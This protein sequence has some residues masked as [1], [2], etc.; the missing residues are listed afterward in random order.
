MPPIALAHRRTELNINKTELA[1]K[2]KQNCQQVEINASVTAQV[3]TSWEDDVSQPTERII[4]HLAKALNWETF[5]LLQATGWA[6]ATLSSEMPLGRYAVEQFTELGHYVID[7]VITLVRATVFWGG[8]GLSGWIIIEIIKRSSGFYQPDPS[9][10]T[11]Q[12]LNILTQFDIAAS[13]AG[14][15]VQLILD[16]SDVIGKQLE[17]IFKRAN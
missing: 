3:I 4:P 14:F 6:Y 2:V 7:R 10:F 5:E 15:I 12:V 9:R 11:V 13:A 8:L 16:W 17:D 1:D